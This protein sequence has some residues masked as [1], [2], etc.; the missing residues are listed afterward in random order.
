MIISSLYLLMNNVQ[1]QSYLYIRQKYISTNMWHTNHSMTQG[2][3]KIQISQYWIYKYEQFIPNE[4]VNKHNEMITLNHHSTGLLSQT[5]I[6]S[7]PIIIFL[8]L[9]IS[10]D[11]NNIFSKYSFSCHTQTRDWTG[12]WKS[13]AKLI[14][15][16]YPGSMLGVDQ[17]TL[18]KQLSY[19]LLNLAPSFAESYEVTGRGRWFPCHTFGIGPL[20]SRIWSIYERSL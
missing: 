20:R 7:I 19:L 1:L 2:N 5:K 9:T 11:R 15:T 10:H 3:C 4:I 6:I 8:N 17:M 16:I 12:T 13:L 18:E 14:Q